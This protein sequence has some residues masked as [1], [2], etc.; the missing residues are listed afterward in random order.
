MIRPQWILT[1]R[2]GQSYV[3][4]RAIVT[5]RAAKEYGWA[6]DFAKAD[7]SSH[8]KFPDTGAVYYFRN[9][10]MAHFGMWN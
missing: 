10:D 3:V 9:G 5:R 8:E 4:T 1:K 7:A 6:P 2:N